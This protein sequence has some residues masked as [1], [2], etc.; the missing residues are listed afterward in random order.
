M[1]ILCRVLDEALQRHLLAEPK[2]TFKEA[3]EKALAAETALF[4]A[5]LLRQQQLK[6]CIKATILEALHRLLDQSTPWWWEA[7]RETVYAQA[8]QLLQT[9]K[10]LAHYDENKSLAVVCDASPHGLGTLLFHL[11]H[12][13]QEKPIFLAFRTMTTKRSERFTST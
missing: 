7:K 3:E 5:R 10:V 9:D 13:G 1:S 6:H 4:N 8:K 12:D 11:E 2:L